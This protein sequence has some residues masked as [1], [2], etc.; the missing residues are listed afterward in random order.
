MTRL[1]TLAMVQSPHEDLKAFA[2]GVERR[3]RSTSCDLLVYPEY[4]VVREDT[5][6]LEESFAEFAESEAEPLNGPRGDTFSQ[7]AGDLKTWLIPGSVIERG[8]DG[9]LYNTAL[10]YSPEGQ[11]AAS[12][13]K[14]FPFRPVETVAPGSGFTVFEM[15]G[16]GRVGLSVCYDAWFPEVSRHLAW[17]GAELV[18]NV[19]ATSTNDRTQEVVLAQANAIVNQNFVASVNGAGPLGMGKSLLVDPEG[20]IRTQ[21]ITAEPVTLVDVIDL[22][23]VTSV[24][25]RG[26]A[27]VTRPWD[28]FQGSDTPVQLPFYNGQIDPEKW[29][30]VST[31]TTSVETDKGEPS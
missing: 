28:H 12:Y 7:L 20:R 19:V 25:K 15:A 30:S 24:R 4:H 21:S 5:T 1:L 6:G 22:D 9:A 31:R 29:R 26:T 13:R 23:T 14:T 17:M 18:V 2:S 10:V 27:G 3:L 8:D 11:L 16:F